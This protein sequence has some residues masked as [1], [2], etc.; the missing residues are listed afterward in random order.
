MADTRASFEDRRRFVTGAAS[1]ALLLPVVGPLAGGCRAAA[2]DVQT[3]PKGP[4]G[5]GCEGCEAIHAGMPERPSWRTRIAPE[6]EPGEAMEIGGAVYRTD[7]KTPAP[8]VILYVYH[9]DAEGIYPPAPGASG[10]ARNHGRLRGWMKTGADG[11]Y[12]FVTIRP[13]SYPGRRFPAHVHAIVKEP[14][15][16]EYWIDDFHFDDD[17]LLTEAER[18]GAPKRGGSGV[19]RL[20]K[21]EGVWVGRRDIVLGLNVPGYHGE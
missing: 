3:R 16:N 1:F 13:A 2:T 18:A 4:V 15:L 8:D 7:A 5:G 21:R 9:T 14:D 20:E 11:A 19:I 12:R 6:G 17:P 10:S